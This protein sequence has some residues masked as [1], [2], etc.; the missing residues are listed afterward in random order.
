LSLEQVNQC[1]QKNKRENCA[2]HSA[3]PRSRSTPNIRC[4]KYPAGMRLPQVAG[5]YRASGL[6]QCVT[7]HD[8]D[9]DDET[10][11]QDKYG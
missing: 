11:E 6:W 9:E 10:D 4:G 2:D 3:S 7:Q 8:D 1:V 5:S